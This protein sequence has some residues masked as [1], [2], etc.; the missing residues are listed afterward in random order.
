M[1]ELPTNSEETFNADELGRYQA[2]STSAVLALLL[3]LVSPAALLAPVFISVP[4]LAVVVASI[5]ISK[6]SS[7]DCGLAG[8]RL[9]RVGLVLAL[10]FGVAS[11]TRIAVINVLVKNLYET[12][13]PAETDQQ[14]SVPV[15]GTP[16]NNHASHDHS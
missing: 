8:A 9:A 11:C 2:I 10:V 15:P 5:A 7:P 4:L 12:Q 3:G 14:D 13:A 16:N 1:S 6:T